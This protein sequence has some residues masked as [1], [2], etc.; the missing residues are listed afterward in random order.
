MALVVFELLAPFEATS[1]QPARF[2][3]PRR[4]LNYQVIVE[5]GWAKNSKLQ[6]RHYLH[7]WILLSIYFKVHAWGG[8]K[9]AALAESLFILAK[10]TQ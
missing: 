6:L 1:Y 10:M 4:I 2:I 3:E 7:Y 9:Y 8:L 5:N